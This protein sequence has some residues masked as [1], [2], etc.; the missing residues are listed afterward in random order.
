MV[1]KN[2]VK[3]AL[4]PLLLISGGIFAADNSAVIGQWSLEL[5]VQGQT[6][7]VS[8]KISE[9]GDRLGGT[10]AGP[11]GS[12]TLSGVNFDGNTLSFSMQTQQGSM[13]VSLELMD[14]TLDGGLAS[15]M[16]DLPVVGKKS[17]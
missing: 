13:S 3:L 14:N 12:N 11:A 1:I 4:L 2:T 7:P 17:S 6:V 10:W 15:P 8:L 5:S 16:G 9:D